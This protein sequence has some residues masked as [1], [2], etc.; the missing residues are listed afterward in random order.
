MR[1]AIFAVI[2]LAATV[3]SGQHWEIEAIDPAS[4]SNWRDPVSIRVLSDGRL[5]VCY[6]ASGTVRVAIRDSI[7]LFEDVD[8]PSAEPYP[9]MDVGC[10][11]RVAV[12]YGD[13]DSMRYAVRTDSGWVRTAIPYAGGTPVLAHDSAETPYV[14]FGGG[15]W[16]DR[17]LLS[18]LSDSGWTLDTIHIGVQMGFSALTYGPVQFTRDGRATVFAGHFYDWNPR[19]YGGAVGLYQCVGDSWEELWSSQVYGLM[20]ALSMALDTADIPVCCHWLTVE[21]GNWLVCAGDTIGG[22]SSSATVRIDEL[23]RPG[24]AHTGGWWEGGPLV[25]TWRSNSGW[26][27]SVVPEVNDVYTC[28]FVPGDDGQPLIAYRRQDSGVW[29]ARGVNIV[30]CEEPEPPSV[31]RLPSTATVV[32]GMLRLPE[33]S[34]VLL[35]IAGRSVLDLAPG[36]NDVRHLSPG[37]YF[38]L[39]PHPDPRARTHRRPCPQGERERRQASNVHKV[40]I[41]R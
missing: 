27:S 31:V 3:A 25:F 19:V 17:V 41:Q 28:D 21:G 39:T 11:G 10:N 40:I 29:L 6:A 32:R 22:F 16:G 15:E 13:A 4:S 35:D 2:L 33:A 23:N 8:V 37:V 7:W 24:V 5:C 20:M 18:V 14:L 34:G 26:R 1:K 30:G 9:S 36:E 12:S 38:V